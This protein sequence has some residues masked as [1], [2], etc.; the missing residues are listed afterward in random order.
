MHL[1][2]ILSPEIVQ[3]TNIGG[4][5]K[6]NEQQ[7]G[8][9][10]NGETKFSVFDKRIIGFMNMIPRLNYKGI[11]ADFKLLILLCHH[12][13]HCHATNVRF[14]TIYKDQS[15]TIQSH[16]L[17]YNIVPFRLQK[18]FYLYHAEGVKE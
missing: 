2:S 18:L 10:L 8:T 1:R 11:R 4:S 14:T 17:K 9:K 16:L 7:K 6:C 15:S 5:T 12:K 3:I 13:F